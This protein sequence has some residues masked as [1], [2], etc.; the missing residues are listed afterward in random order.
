VTST[1]A[2]RTAH[3][4]HPPHTVEVHPTHSSTVRISGR[5][6][7]LLAIICAI[8]VLA[9]SPFRGY[10]GQRAQLAQLQQQ[11]AVLEH[12]NARLEQKI[13][14]LSDPTYLERLARECLGMV[15]PGETAFVIVP[16]DG[17]PQPPDC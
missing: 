7:V 5:A 8:G 9:I 13:D 2:T 11:A 12:Q 4:P 17:R 16:K 1:S 6:L 14:E 3:P 15:K 10:L